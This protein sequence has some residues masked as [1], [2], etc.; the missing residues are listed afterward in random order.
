MLQ[1]FIHI[2][3]HPLLEHIFIFDL[4]QSSNVNQLHVITVKGFI[5]Y[6]HANSQMDLFVSK[7]V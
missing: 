4:K 6:I 1:F 5:V 2:L 3:C 7:L